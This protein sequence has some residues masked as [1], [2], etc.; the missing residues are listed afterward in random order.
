MYW[1]DEKTNPVWYF[2]KNLNNVVP[3]QVPTAIWNYVMAMSDGR[4]GDR[5]GREQCGVR[6]SLW[7]AA[8]R[9]GRSATEGDDGCEPAA[10]LQD[11]AFY[12]EAAGPVYMNPVLARR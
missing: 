10:D 3:V 6:I 1:P 7:L 2:D 4:V 5:G 11:A 9:G 12:C 8:N